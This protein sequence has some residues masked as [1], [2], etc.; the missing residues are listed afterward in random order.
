MRL[1]TT[2]APMIAAMM[3]MEASGGTSTHRDDAILSP[4]N[5]R[6][7]ASPRWRCLRSRIAAARTM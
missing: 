4:A 5:T 3:A 1:A 7:P 2:A 6:M